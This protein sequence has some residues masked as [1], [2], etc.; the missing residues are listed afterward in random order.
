MLKKSFLRFLIIGGVSTAINYSVFHVFLAVFGMHYA[1]SSGVGYCTGLVVGYFFNK[2]WTFQA[3]RHS[4]AA[5]TQYICVYLGSLTLSLVLLSFLIEGLSFPAW[6]ANIIAI[7]LTT[8]TNFVGLRFWVFTPES[9]YELYIKDLISVSHKLGASM[10]VVQGGGGNTSIKFAGHYM[11][12]KASGTTLSTMS[13]SKG[14]S[15]VDYPH[16]LNGLSPH[17]TESESEKVLKDSVV[18]LPTMPTGRPSMETGFHAVLGRVVLHTHSVYINCIACSE[19]G[20][21]LCESLFKDTDIFPVWIDYV[22]PGLQLSVAVKQAVQKQPD[23]TVFILASHGIVVT[24][25]TSKEAYV[26]Y[27]SV[28]K[29]IKTGLSLSDMTETYTLEKRDEDHYVMPLPDADDVSLRDVL[30]PDQ[31]I[32]LTHNVTREKEG[33]VFKA[34]LSKAEGMAET[35]L[36]KIYIES[37]INRLGYTPVSLNDEDVAL[38]LNMPSEAYRKAVIE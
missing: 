37:E 8:I 1:M 9:E 23:A 5:I 16:V 22:A 33:L 18:Q 15:I 35:V 32:Y 3:A 21:S 25:E 30:F 19:N 4:V 31:A 26:L 27:E 14:I 28:T 17:T 2:S 7:G 20:R 34:S 10:A 38:V 36:A 24:A 29:I 6:F 13:A 11:A 12:V